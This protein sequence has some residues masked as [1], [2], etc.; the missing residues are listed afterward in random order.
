MALVPLPLCHYTVTPGSISGR[1]GRHT[2]DLLDVVED[3]RA[4]V[5]GAGLERRWRAD[6]LQHRYLNGLLPLAN[7]ALRAEHAGAGDAG[8]REAVAAA[9]R[10]VRPSELVRLAAAGRLRTAAAA[11]LLRALP[12]VYSSGLAR[13]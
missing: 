5:A 11:G 10:L 8:T 6:L 7:M 1:F 9:R 4:E 2:F 12:G 13:R 3:V